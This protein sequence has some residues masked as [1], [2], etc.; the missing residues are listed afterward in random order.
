[1]K[2]LIYSGAN[3]ADNTLPL[4]R[5]MKRKSIDV[6]LLIHLND[7]KVNLFN[8]K[9]LKSSVGIY[10]ATEYPSFQRYEKYCDLRNVYIENCPGR[11][12]SLKSFRST[13]LV[14]KFIK[15]GHFDVI[16]TDILM[17]L[18]KIVLLRY[19]KKMV[20]VLHEPFIRE[21][22]NIIKKV[23]RLISFRSIPKIVILNNSFYEKFCSQYNI[24]PQRVLINKLGPLDC[25]SVF[26][27]EAKAFSRKR[28]VF[29]GRIVHYKGLEYLC[30]AMT[31]VHEK[32]PEAELVI[33]GGGEF[34]FDIEPYKNLPYIHINNTFLDMEELARLID[35]AA[36]TVCPYT[37]ASQSG[38][39]ITSF[40]MEKPV[41]GTDLE[42]MHEMIV[43]GESGLLVPPRD[44]EA[45]ARAMEKLLNDDS[46]YN[47][48]VNNIRERN[49][50]DET[51]SKVV[52]KYVDFYQKRI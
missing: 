13:L 20:W 14:S 9:K 31:K 36:F 6:T 51:W 47:Y 18:W 8:E 21:R 42:T 35:S 32:D 5:E 22:G 2:V 34:Y 25:I 4:Y 30:E 16:H 28:I 26:A 40:V 41:I 10:K 52:D 38:S 12:R 48:L 50:N 3:F 11:L 29:W 17:M 27:N 15:K 49:A 45:L 19:C 37:S 1:M 7:P 24:T 44:S 43:D 33:A 23:T 39:V 46:L